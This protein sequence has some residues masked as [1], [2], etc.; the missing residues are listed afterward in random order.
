LYLK[1]AWKIL[2]S[3]ESTTLFYHFL[4]SA[5][6]TGHSSL[7]LWDFTFAFSLSKHTHIIIVYGPFPSDRFIPL[8]QEILL[9][10]EFDHNIS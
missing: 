4:F 8:Y 3:L 10:I 2:H 9:N 1:F 5:P 6:V 7:Q